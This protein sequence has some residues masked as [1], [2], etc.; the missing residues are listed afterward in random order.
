MSALFR[1][2]WEYILPGRDVGVVLIAQGLRKRES[3][4]Y[5]Q[6]HPGRTHSTRNVSTYALLIGYRISPASDTVLKIVVPSSQSMR[7]HN[8][9]SRWKRASSLGTKAAPSPTTLFFSPDN[10][11]I[12]PTPYII[13]GIEYH[14]LNRLNRRCSAYSLPSLRSPHKDELVSDVFER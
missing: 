3:E 5:R 13:G 6:A 10:G 8:L 11:R 4:V 7:R 1:V 14:R 9:L 2:A 12:S